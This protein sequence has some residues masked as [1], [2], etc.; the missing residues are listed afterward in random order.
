MSVF[1][2]VKIHWSSLLGGAASVISVLAAN[3]DKLP[4]KIATPVAVIGTLIAMFTHKAVQSA[5]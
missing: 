1:S 3:A 5:K 2:G 4:A